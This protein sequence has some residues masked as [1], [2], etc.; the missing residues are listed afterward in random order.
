MKMIKG[1]YRQIFVSI[2]FKKLLIRFKS[3]RNDEK[4]EAGKD[5]PFS[6]IIEVRRLELDIFKG[7]HKMKK[8]L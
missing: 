4:F 6:E 3:E 5:M 7:E 1:T 8:E 2:D